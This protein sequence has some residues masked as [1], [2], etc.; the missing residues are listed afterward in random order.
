MVSLLQT[1][2]LALT[3]PL[4]SQ[5]HQTT[6]ICWKAPISFCSTINIQNAHKPTHAD[7]IATADISFF[8][9]SPSSLSSDVYCSVANEMLS[10]EPN[11][12]NSIVYI[13][14]NWMCLYCCNWRRTLWFR[15]T[16]FTCRVCHQLRRHFGQW[17]LYDMMYSLEISTVVLRVLVEIKNPC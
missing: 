8:A 15:I 4:S 7:I 16:Q 9:L 2:L 5:Q 11:K 1:S 13:A 17:R 12:M 6:L 10:A 3:T 14:S